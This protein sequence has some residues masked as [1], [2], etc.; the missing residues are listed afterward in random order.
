MAHP[1]RRGRVLCVLWSGQ[2]T[3]LQRAACAQLSQ[4][5]DGVQCARA[6]RPCRM[7]LHGLPLMRQV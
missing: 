6:L 5:V 7:P 3:A 1:A 4:C 2:D